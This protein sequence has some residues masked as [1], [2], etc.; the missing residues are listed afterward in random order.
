MV[1][2]FFLPFSVPL[3]FSC[4]SLSTSSPRE[5]LIIVKTWSAPISQEI[6]PCYIPLMCRFPA[7][8]WLL[9]RWNTEHDGPW[10]CILISLPAAF[11]PGAFSVL[12]LSTSLACAG[13]GPPNRAGISLCL[14]MPISLFHT[15][16]TI[17]PLGSSNHQPPPYALTSWVGCSTWPWCCETGRRQEADRDWMNLSDKSRRVL[18][19]EK[20]L[21]TFIQ[22]MHTQAV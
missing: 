15:P 13:H 16:F 10:G 7:G 14:L 21:E 6:T 18:P 5:A 1:I 2:F 22:T 8:A 11:L 3:S 4:L 20:L 12:F 9:V 17:A 19:I